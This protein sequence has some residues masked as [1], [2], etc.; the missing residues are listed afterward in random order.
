MNWLRRLSGQTNWEKYLFHE[1]ETCFFR[2]EVTVRS[3]DNTG[4]FL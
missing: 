2:R 3:N 1:H 4:K